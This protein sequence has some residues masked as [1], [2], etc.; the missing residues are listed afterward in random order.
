[1]LVAI[2]IR[3]ST[4]DQADEGLGPGEPG[5]NLGSLAV[6]FGPVEGHETH[7]VGTRPRQTIQPNYARTIRPITPTARSPGAL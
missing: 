2:Y 1:M 6:H 7:V 3:V 5:E 4:E